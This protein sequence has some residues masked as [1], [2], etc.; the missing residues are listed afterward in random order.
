MGTIFVMPLDMAIVAGLADDDVNAVGFWY[1]A[2]VHTMPHPHGVREPL[3]VASPCDAHV[4][5]GKALG[6]APELDTGGG[7]RPGWA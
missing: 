1:G 5:R 3:T 6:A 7:V 4:T 2:G